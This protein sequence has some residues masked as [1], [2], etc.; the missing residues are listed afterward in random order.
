MPRLYPSGEAGASR[1]KSNLPY[2]FR[3][4]FWNFRR[5]FG[6][7]PRGLHQQSISR[8]KQLATNH[9]HQKPTASNSSKGNPKPTAQAK[10][11]SGR[12]KKQGVAT[13]DARGHQG[14]RFKQTLEAYRR[15][16]RQHLYHPCYTQQRKVVA[17]HSL[18]LCTVAL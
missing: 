9:C 1:F 16:L 3:G 10:P 14:K 18:A 7:I 2:S 11:H 8:S 13:V 4:S 12:G 6:P 5:F 15:A 17:H